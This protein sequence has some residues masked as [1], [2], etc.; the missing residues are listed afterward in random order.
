MAEGVAEVEQC[1]LTLFA[2][3]TQHDLGF[4]FAGAVDGMGHGCRLQ[5]QQLIEV[6]FDPVEKHRIEDQ[7]VFDDLGQTRA[8]FAR[9]QRGQRGGV[10]HH[11]RRLVKSTDEVLAAGMIDAGLA[12]D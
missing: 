9:R 5:A 4:E 2:L 6:L 10:G 3:I 11:D 8:Q 1:A 7:R 12:T